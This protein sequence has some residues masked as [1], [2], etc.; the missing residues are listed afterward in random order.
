MCSWRVSFHLVSS[1]RHPAH[2]LQYLFTMTAQAQKKIQATER[3]VSQI[4]S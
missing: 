2:A 1:E 3:F 4:N